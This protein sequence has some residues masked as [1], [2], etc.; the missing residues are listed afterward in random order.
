MKAPY[1]ENVRITIEWGDEIFQWEGFA[2]NIAYAILSM[3]EKWI[4][5]IRE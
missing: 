4:E 5:E 1:N 3:E 2:K